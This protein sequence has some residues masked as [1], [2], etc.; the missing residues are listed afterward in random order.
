MRKFLYLYNPYSG[1]QVG[2]HDLDRVLGTFYKR[3]VYAVPHRLFTLEN[4]PVLDA[5]LADKEAFDGVIISG[6]DG[7]VGQMIDKMIKSGNDTP[8]GIVPGGTCNDFARNLM[9]PAALMDCIEVFCDYRVDHVD[10]L[11]ITTAEAEQYICN[12]IAAGV[13]VGV[14]HTTSPEFKKVFGSLAYYI[15]ALGELADMKTFNITVETEKETVQTE[16]LVFA[17]L[18]GTDVGGMKNL[19]SEADIKDGLMNIMIVK[20]CNPVER[21]AVGINLLAHKGDKNIVSLNCSRCKIKADR[22]MDVS[23]DGENGLK[24]PFEI[25]NLNQ[26]LNVIVPEAFLHHGH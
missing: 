13:F 19:I 23:L 14:S 2:G 24:L 7:T 22:E 20:N 25:E 9:M 26:K 12:S 21:A 4:D 5:L 3:G 18:N 6:G 17:V 15:A 8:V 11:K 16:A 1:S 10:L